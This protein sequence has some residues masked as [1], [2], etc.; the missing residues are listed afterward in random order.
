MATAVPAARRPGELDL[1]TDDDQVDAGG[2]LD[3]GYMAARRVLLDALTALQ[4]HGKAIIVVGAQ[5][6]YLHTGGNDIAIAPYTT[7]GD[8][9]LDPSLLGADPELE[10]AMRGAGFALLL[11]GDRRA[12]PGTWTA[13]VDVGGG[14]LVVPVDLIVPEAAAT[15]G[16]RRGARLGTHGN[17][18]ARRSVGLE[19]ALVDHKLMTVT[20]LDPAD[21]RAVD[22]EVAGMPAMIVAKAHKIHDRVRSGRAD[23]MSDKDASDIYRIMQ[24]VSPGEAGAVLRGLRRHAMAG[25]ATDAAVR[26]MDDLFGRRGA[27]GVKMAQRALRLA[28]PEQQVAAVCLSFTERLLAAA[29]QGQGKDE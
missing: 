1:S 6:I 18:A 21:P 28:V 4:P 9:A 27:V 15:G 3:P 17:R 25:A 29:R 8:L 13:T 10:T 12:Q 5:A 2:H 24:T 22:V 7:D 19:A 14:R 11:H 26:Y 16:G 20:A 23:R